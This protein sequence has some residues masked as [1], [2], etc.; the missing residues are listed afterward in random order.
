MKSYNHLYE[1]YL[2][3]D[4]LYEAVKLATQNKVGKKSKR[5]KRIYYREHIEELKPKLLNYAENFKHFKHHEVQIYDG[6]RRK[7]RTIIVP[8]MKEQVTHH[9]IINVMKPIFMRS[10][11]EHSYGSIPGRGSHKAKKAI[12]KWIKN[13]EKGTRYFLK[14]DVKK[15]FES[16]PHDILKAKLAKIIHDERFLNVINEVIDTTEVGIPLGFYTSQWFANFYLTELD[17]Y[18]KN[19]LGAKHYVRYMDDM[20]IFGSNK[21]TLH[22]Y[23]KLISIFLRKKLGLNLKENWTVCPLK[24]F[25][26]GGMDWRYQDLD[27]MGFR[28]I[29]GKTVLRRA[30]MYKMTRKARSICKKKQKRKPITIH[31]ARSMLSYLGWIKHTD[32]YWMYQKYIKP[33]VSF[34]RLKRLISK[35]DRRNLECLKKQKTVTQQSHLNLS[36]IAT[37]F[38]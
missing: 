21:K 30:L 5:N 4:N 2:S 3:E 14:M 27:F 6:V 19:E 28:F 31:D 36:S 34:K 10:M 35:H 17:H 29:R 7:K 23:R 11:Y 16:V 33:Y 8:S 15:Y 25:P 22:R 37:Q 24:Y 20:V 1:K 13:D 38:T 18:I 26:R 12:E 32:T 9:M